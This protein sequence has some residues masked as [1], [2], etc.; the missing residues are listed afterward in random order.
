MP[1]SSTAERLNAIKQA[2]QAEDETQK[3]LMQRTPYSSHIAR[4]MR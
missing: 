1:K 3:K 2:Q 4:M